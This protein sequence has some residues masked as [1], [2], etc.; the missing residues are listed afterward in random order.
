MWNGACGHQVAIQFTKVYQQFGHVGD[1]VASR[2]LFQHASFAGDWQAVQSTSGGVL[3]ILGDRT[4]V[5]ISWLH[6]KQTAVS[7]SGTK[8]EVISW[9]HDYDWMV[10]QLKLS[11]RALSL[12]SHQVTK[13]KEAPRTVIHSLSKLIPLSWCHPTSTFPTTVFNLLIVFEDDEAVI[14][15]IIKG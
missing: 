12:S 14:E 10:C 9:V 5:L 6:K 4:F 15:M 11:G 7:H 1:H 3:C 2:G 8:A 13:R